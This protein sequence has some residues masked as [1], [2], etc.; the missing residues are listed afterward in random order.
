MRSAAPATIL[1]AALVRGATAQNCN[2]PEMEKTCA[3]HS[4]PTGKDGKDPPI[5][6]LCLNPC[7]DAMMRCA[8]NA[9]FGKMVGGDVRTQMGNMKRIC[10]AGKGS[11]GDGV[12]NIEQIPTYSTALHGRDPTCADDLMKEMFDC[13]DSPLLAKDRTKI[14]SARASCQGG[15]EGSAGDGKCDLLAISKYA[16]EEEE[17]GNRQCDSNI[18]KEAFDCVSTMRLLC[19]VCPRWPL[20]VR[21]PSHKTRCC[22]Q[23]DSS[24]LAAQRKEIM[25]MRTV[26]Q[27]RTGVWFIWTPTWCGWPS[28]CPSCLQLSRCVGACV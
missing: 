9:A 1:L 2:M 20:R 4:V 24:A 14:L 16:K 26:C 17:T 23:V 12:C 6:S 13:I 21:C 10:K 11:A 22:A 28:D 18:M 15:G 8:D 25:A 27:S 5:A 19:P 3:A 7:V